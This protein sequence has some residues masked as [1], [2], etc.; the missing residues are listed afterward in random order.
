MRA[1]LAAVFVLFFVTAAVAQVTT[2]SP[3]PNNPTPIEQAT[4]DETKSGS[5]G[6]TGNDDPHEP[7]KPGSLPAGQHVGPDLKEIPSQPK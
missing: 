3:G 2:P 1:A 7:G 4:F 5:R 6:M